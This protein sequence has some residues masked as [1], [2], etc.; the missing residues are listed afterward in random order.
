MKM[1]KITRANFHM[2]KV[3]SSNCLSYSTTSPKNKEKLQ[4]ITFQ[5]MKL[6]IF[7][8]LCKVVAN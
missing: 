4:I 3:T 5:K 2:P 8:H 7:W 1:V 6:A